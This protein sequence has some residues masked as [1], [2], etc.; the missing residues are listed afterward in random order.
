[1]K[2]TH[3]CTACETIHF[4]GFKCSEC[5]RRVEFGDRDFKAC[6]YCLSPYEVKQPYQLW[7]TGLEPYAPTSKAN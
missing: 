4:D 2:I 3:L 5:G 7:L 1:M 6:P